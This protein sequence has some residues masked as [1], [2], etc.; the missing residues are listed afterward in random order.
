MRS[1]K[2]NKIKRPNEDDPIAGKMCGYP[3][4][5]WDLRWASKIQTDLARCL[6]T[7]GQLIKA[8]A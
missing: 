6:E 2:V 8:A 5:H 7:K 1:K 4:K 3:E